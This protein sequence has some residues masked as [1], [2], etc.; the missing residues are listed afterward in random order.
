MLLVAGRYTKCTQTAQPRHKGS[1]GLIINSLWLQY[2]SEP[3]S[4]RKCATRTGGDATGPPWWPQAGG[5]AST[6]ADHTPLC[7]HT[8]GGACAY[9]PDHAMPHTTDLVSP[10]T[11]Q[12]HNTCTCFIHTSIFPHTDIQRKCCHPNNV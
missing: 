1:P 10:V 11:T 7:Q 2:G 6:S 9:H 3:S 5:G 12:H 4:A 8:C